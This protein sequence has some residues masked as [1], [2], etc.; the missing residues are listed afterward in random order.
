MP[1]RSS[2]FQL[3]IHQIGDVANR[4]LKK[5]IHHV[6]GGSATVGTKDY[7]NTWPVG[8]VSAG[9][10]SNSAVVIVG[11]PKTSPRLNS[12]WL[13]T[14]TEPRLQRSPKELEQNLGVFS[15]QW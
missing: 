6:W 8:L 9:L 13:V 5:D 7:C 10:R 4:V 3:G 11:S 12:T 1:N 15:R 14:T 2:A